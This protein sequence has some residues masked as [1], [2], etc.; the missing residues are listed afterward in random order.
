MLCEGIG[1]GNGWIFVLGGRTIINGDR[2]AR[3]HAQQR[4][5]HGANGHLASGSLQ[6]GVAAAAHQLPALPDGL[7]RA[8]LEHKDRGL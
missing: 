1:R 6:F 4:A 5:D 7:R 2:E 3:R 8:H